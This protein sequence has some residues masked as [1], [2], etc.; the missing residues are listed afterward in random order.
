MIVGGLSLLDTWV[1]KL[2]ILEMTEMAT[3]ALDYTQAEVEV[4]SSLGPLAT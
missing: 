4:G 2:C 1:A 3:V